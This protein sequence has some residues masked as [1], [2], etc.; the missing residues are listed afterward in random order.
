[1]PEDP[2]AIGAARALVTEWF[3]DARCAWLGG[4]IVLGQG[5]PGSDLDITVLL[6]GPPAPFRDSRRFDGWPVELFV[7]TESSLAHY[8]DRE[9][10][11]GRPT[12]ARL[13]G[14]SRVLVDADGSGAGWQAR[15][16]ELLDAGPPELDPETHSSLRY[17][18]TDLLDDLVH[19]R[20]PHEALVTAALLADEAVRLLL[21]GERHWWAAASGWPGSSRT[22]TQTGARRGRRAT[23]TPSGRRPRETPTPWWRSAATCSH[24]TA[25]PSS[26]V[27]D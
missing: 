3:P 25:A 5:T 8:V 26:R 17:A 14:R 21:A 16:A 24:A 15:C 11:S 12:L 23:R 18:V 13:V 4:S 2:D 9:V 22:W 27:I 20:S 1:M 7:H 19:A 10:A 6:P